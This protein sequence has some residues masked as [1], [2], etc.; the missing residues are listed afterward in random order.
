MS[1]VASMAPPLASAAHAP[2][3][4][5][6]H[7]TGSSS[8]QWSALAQRLAPAYR[9]IAADLIAHG[10]S[11]PWAR[12]EAPSIEAELDALSPLVE[13]QSGAVHVVGHSYGGAVAIRLAMRHPGQVATVT[14]FEPVM[15]RQLLDASPDDEGALEA[16]R[17]AGRI[18]AA[19]CAGQAA[20]AGRTF[21]DYWSGEGAW[22]R[23]EEGARRTIAERMPAAFAC[24]QALFGDTTARQDLARL[25][26][27]TLLMS[28]GRS[29]ASGRAATK[30][31]A[32]VLPKSW[33]KSF[34]A[35][36][37]MGPVESPDTVNAQVERFIGAA[38]RRS[39]AYRPFD[40]GNF[41]GWGAPAA[42]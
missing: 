39:V 21:F 3:V 32:E 2:A 19:L 42:A 34:P 35:L 6:L 9:V 36:G 23:L 10:R 18:H 16:V 28:G 27:P 1:A 5:C 40:T 26:V 33:W 7:S 17:V 12:G 15:F 13:A 22:E 14:A 8:R 4:I 30:L 29:P 11:R 24:F 31:L 37:H 41:P 20:Q 38:H 25:R